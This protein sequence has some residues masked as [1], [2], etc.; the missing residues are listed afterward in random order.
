M[1]RSTTHQ[2]VVAA[3]LLALGVL[4]PTAFHLFDISGVMFLPMHLPVLLCGLLCGW[5]FGGMTGFLVPLLASLLTG[6]PPIYPTALAM[7]FEL[8]AYGIVTGLLI[9]RFNVFVSL[10]GAML[11]GR[12]VMGLA[13]YVFLGLAGNAYTLNMFLGGAFLTVWPGILIQLVFV[14]A[15]ILAL[16]RARLI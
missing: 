5:K 16:K 12:V 13:N 15:I 14:P 9:K 2:I 4:L 8:A 11:A 10:I 6:K 1:I 3:L 7:A